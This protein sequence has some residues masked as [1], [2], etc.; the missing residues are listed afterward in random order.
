MESFKK[1]CEDYLKNTKIHLYFDNFQNKPEYTDDPRDCEAEIEKT[2]KI[3]GI[4]CHVIICVNAQIKEVLYSYETYY[5]P[6]DKG[7]EVEEV[8]DFNVTIISNDHLLDT[9]FDFCELID[10]GVNIK[11]QN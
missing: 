2:A 5:Q 10:L 1:H 6:E 11:V 8:N 7:Y 3:G 9:N 4:E